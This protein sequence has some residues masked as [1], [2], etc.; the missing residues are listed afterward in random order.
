MA[1]FINVPEMEKEMEP[2]EPPTWN[3]LLIV[4]WMTQILSG[5]GPS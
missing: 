1:E 5:S 3:F 2:A 4:P